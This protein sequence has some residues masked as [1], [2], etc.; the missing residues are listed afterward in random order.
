MLKLVRRSCSVLLILCLL[1]SLSVS[2]FA[3]EEKIATSS[4]ENALVTSVPDGFWTNELGLSDS[5]VKRL[6]SVAIESSKHFNEDNN[7]FT[8]D[9][10]SFNLP[11]TEEIGDAV[12]L[13]IFKHIPEVIYVKH[14]LYKYQE[15]QDGILLNITFDRL[16]FTEN[17]FKTMLAA[18]EK[19]AKE[20]TAD[21]VNNKNL[22][23][24]Q[25]ALLLHDRLA[26][27][28]YYDYKNYLK[29]TVPAVD[30]TMY[31]ALCLGPTVCE[32][33][34]R[35]YMY[36]LQ[37]VGINSYFCQSDLIGHGWVI[38]ELDGKRYHVDMTYNDPFTSEE[39]DMYNYVEH[40]YFLLSTAKLKSMDA[41]H[42]KAFDIDTS[43]VATTYDSYF[44]QDSYSA[45]AYVNNTLYYV[46]NTNGMLKTWNKNGSKS[47]VKQLTI[48][49]RLQEYHDGLLYNTDKEIRW[50]DPKTGED[51]FVY[52]VADNELIY[53]FRVADGKLSM[54]LVTPNEEMTA[55]VEFNTTVPMPNLF[56]TSSGKTGDVN[57]DG[58]ID[59]K[60]RTFL[61]RYLAE[62]HTYGGTNYDDIDLA[63]A[64]VNGDKAVDAKDRTVLARHLAEWHIYQGTDYDQY[65]K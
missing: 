44:W 30:F 11:G 49:S 50:Y 62:W 27:I 15:K 55:T 45:F 17:D 7:S 19:K 20:L 10:S 21:L 28:S 22:T 6:I 23:D 5:E 4:V 59:A 29:G 36:L 33:Y 24:V 31:S 8:V 43:P 47:D 1:A 18:C 35:A 56:P 63:A 37:Q 34:S 64:D 42:G 65:F 58:A 16:G 39:T 25:K 41:Q 57:R 32:G 61:A 52:A 40:D 3:A 26:A 12:S 2:A 53:S 48:L 54:H 38:V 9:V 14:A 46:D 13:L 60:D 51:R